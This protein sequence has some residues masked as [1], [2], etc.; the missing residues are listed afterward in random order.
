MKIAVVDGSD[1][2]ILSV[3]PGS[4]TLFRGGFWGFSPPAM[5]RECL[6]LDGHGWV[7]CGL[8]TWSLEMKEEHIWES[9][10]L[11]G[12]CVVSLLVMQDLL[13][14]PKESSCGYWVLLNQRAE[15]HGESRFC[16]LLPKDRWLTDA[17]PIAHWS[18]G[19]G[20][21]NQMMGLHSMCQDHIRN[22]SNKKWRYLY[23]QFAM[24][25]GISR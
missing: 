18:W 8:V 19:P 11:N 16:I 24:I 23:I 7:C 22:G 3:S 2:G 25:C 20:V 10:F 13:D 15:D 9:N 5:D 17:F 21:L 12:D 6:R 14:Y 1:G 4:T